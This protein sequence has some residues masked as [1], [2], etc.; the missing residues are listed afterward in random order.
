MSSV[1]LYFPNAFEMRTCVYL[2]GNKY[3][4]MG[5][6]SDPIFFYVCVFP[7]F[8]R[9]IFPPPPPFEIIAG[10]VHNSGSRH[11]FSSLQQ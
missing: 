6:V 8:I 4:F 7:P 10:M 3:I 11:C 5:Y 1:L 9:A 2:R